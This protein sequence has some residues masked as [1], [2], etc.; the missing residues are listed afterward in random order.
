MP[1]TVIVLP[2]DGIGP[3]VTREG[4]RVLTAAA[5]LSGLDIALRQFDVGEGVFQASGQYM[6]AEAIRACDEGLAESNAAILFGAVPSEPIGSLRE[7]YDLYANLRPVRA[8]PSLTA[9]SPLKP[10]V[11]DQVDMLIVREL[12]SDVYYGKVRRGRG[13]DGVGEWASQEMYYSEH[14]ARRI[15][16][17]AFEQARRR[18]KKLAFAHKSNAI[19]EVFE[20]WWRV[21]NPLRADY[22]DVAFDD[23]Y[24]DNMAAQLCVRP[25]DFD[26]IL[27]PNMF[28]D[29]LSDLAGGLLGSLGLLPSASLNGQGF[30]LYEPVSG[31]AP[32]IAGQNIANPIGSILSAAMLCEHALGR[33]DARDLIEDAVR[34]AVRTCRTK[35]MAATA[36]FASTSDLGKAVT[37][38][39]YSSRS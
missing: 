29:I 27:A 14:Q 11:I 16:A 32:T 5:E 1:F 22:P 18:R 7:R 26:V 37:E 13:P 6:S 24:V 25:A 38:Q 36:A 20:I 19:G 17:V 9:I 31:T 35:D 34:A 4:V 33:T 39:M 2:G 3:E 12:T 15:A 23:L 10:G 8:D 21:L 28:G 30:G